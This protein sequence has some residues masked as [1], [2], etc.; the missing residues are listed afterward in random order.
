[1]ESLAICKKMGH[2]AIHKVVPE[3]VSDREPLES[4]AKKAGTVENAEVVASLHHAA[5]DSG[6]HR[7][8]FLANGVFTRGDFERIDRQV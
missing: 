1:M 7:A 4:F 5:G 8:V 2:V 3:L 6:F